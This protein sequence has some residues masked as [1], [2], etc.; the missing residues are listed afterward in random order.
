MPKILGSWVSPESG[1]AAPV[2]LPPAR[3]TGLQHS[4]LSAR[5]THPAGARSRVC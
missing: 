5:G 3:S 1:S 4:A 2:R